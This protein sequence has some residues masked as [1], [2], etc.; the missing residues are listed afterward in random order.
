MTA[1]PQLK[2]AINLVRHDIQERSKVGIPDEVIS[3]SNAMGSVANN[4]A[5][6]A[7]GVSTTATAAIH[8][9]DDKLKEE[10]QKLTSELFQYYS[11]GLWGYCMKREGSKIQCSHPSTTFLC[12]TFQPFLALL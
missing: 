12:L 4:G 9:S 6:A 10:A 3:H 7:E 1:F 11:V 8:D 5:A 2:H